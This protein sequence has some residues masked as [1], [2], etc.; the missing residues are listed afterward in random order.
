MV[1]YV[2]RETVKAALDIKQTARRDAQVDRAC[3]TATRMVRGCLHRDFV[4]WLGTKYFDW[5]DLQGSS[6]WR[7]WLDEH[8]AISLTALVAGGVTID[9]AD[10]FLEPV[11]NGPPYDRIEIDLSSAAAFDVGSTHQRDIAATGLWGFDNVTEPAGALAEALDDSETAVDVTDSALAGVGDLLGVGDEHLDVTGKAM[12]DTGVDIDT[13]G[14]LTANKADVSVLLSTTTGAPVVGEIILIDSER[15][16]AVD[17]AGSTL[18]VE[19]AADGSTLA[20]HAAGA[21]IYAPRTLTVLRGA[22]GSTA[23]SHSD[24]SA[25]ARQVFPGPVRDLALAYAVNQ[26][27]QETAGYAREVGSGDNQREASGRGVKELERA[28]RRAC[29]RSLRTLAV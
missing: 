1:W 13:G 16:R 8:E 22:R 15:M 28:A 4:P 26:L 20:A 17:L 29:G 11:N 25:L 23:A 5:P 21:S 14:D 9:P 6:S 7:V 12:K 2:N 24:A 27:L 10:Y 3:G 18:T 19:R